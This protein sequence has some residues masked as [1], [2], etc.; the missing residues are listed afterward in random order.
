[1]I[2]GTSSIEWEMPWVGKLATYFI[3]AFFI[4]VPACTVIVGF[5]DAEVATA[6]SAS[7][8]AK[9]EAKA[10]LA[11]QQTTAVERFIK[12]HSYSAMAARCAV[13]GW[14]TPTERGVCNEASKE[15]ARK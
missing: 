14:D 3:L 11:K 2:D 10:E 4:T 5:D 13:Y 6:E 7:E 8:I 1:M 12:D 15:Q 9:I